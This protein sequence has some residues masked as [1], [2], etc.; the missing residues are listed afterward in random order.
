[1]LKIDESLLDKVVQEARVN[2]RKRKHH[3]FHSSYDEPV[4]R[5]LNAIEPESYIR[6]HMHRNPDKLEIFFVLKGR[7]LVIEFNDDGRIRDHA[8]LDATSSRHGV[9]IY[10]GNYHT[11]I[12]LETGTVAYEVKNGP[13]DPGSDK[14]FAP[15][16]PEE[17]SPEATSY[18]NKLVAEISG[19]GNIG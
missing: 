2:G 12:S 10:P 7:L 9:E 1:M 18:M 19:T 8:L 15:W 6:P 13:F 11:V 5:L 16:A 4:Q 14:N 17:G 3:N